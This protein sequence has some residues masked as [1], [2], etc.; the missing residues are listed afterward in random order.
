MVRANGLIIL[1]EETT[2]VR[3]GALVKVQLLDESMDWMPEPG[4]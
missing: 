3:R 2:A 1:P 4:Y